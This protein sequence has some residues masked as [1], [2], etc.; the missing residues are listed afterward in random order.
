MLGRIIEQRESYTNTINLFEMSAATKGWF[1]VR[2]TTIEG[3]T[4][5]AFVKK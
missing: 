2:V 1:F 5:K 4:V 3:T